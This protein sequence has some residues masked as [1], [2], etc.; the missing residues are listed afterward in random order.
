MIQKYYFQAGSATHGLEH[1]KV[2]CDAS[3][4]E[5]NF[6]LWDFTAPIDTVLDLLDRLETE[7]S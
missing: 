7:R 4:N 5:K 6:H 3:E 1:H 2:Y